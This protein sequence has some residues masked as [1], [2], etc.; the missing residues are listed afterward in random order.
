M[1]SIFLQTFTISLKISLNLWQ[2]IQLQIKSQ[3]SAKAEI[4][5][6]LE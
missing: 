3:E 6:Q 2:R 1:H 5:E 4:A